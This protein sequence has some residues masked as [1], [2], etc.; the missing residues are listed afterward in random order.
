MTRCLAKRYGCILAA[1]IAWT[2]A[3]APA[4]PA[5][6]AGEER[7]GIFERIGESSVP[8]DETAAALEAALRQSHLV[9]HGQM[10]LALGAQAQRARVFVL[11]SPQF[12]AAAAA[13]A[14]NTISAQVLRVAVYEYGKGRKTYIDE[15]NPLAHAMVYYAGSKNYAALLEAARNAGQE[16]RGAVASVPSNNAVSFPLEPSRSESALNGFDGDGAAKM[17]ARW[18]N[19]SQSQRVVLSDKPENFAHVVAQV[20]HAMHAT[21]YKGVEDPSG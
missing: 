17:M 7:Y 4:A 14:P 9:I 16:I 19:W 1:F 11:T 10:D 15:T 12:E 21:S 20:E 6:A 13:E 8:F 5:S 18:R 3:L 2:L